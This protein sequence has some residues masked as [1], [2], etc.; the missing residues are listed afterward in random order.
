M[1]L[2]CTEQINYINIPILLKYYF[3]PSLSVDLGPQLGICVYDK[4]TEKWK[5]DGKDKKTKHDLGANRF[6]FGVGIGLTYNITKDVFIQGRYT[7]GLTKIFDNCQDKNG[8]AQIAIGYR[9]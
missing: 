5:D 3:T 4:F 7:L 8:N 6:D 2:S 9:F 1:R